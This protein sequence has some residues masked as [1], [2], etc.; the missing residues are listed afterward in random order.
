MPN[1]GMK[2][3]MKKPES[4]RKADEDAMKA[5]WDAWMK[6]HAG[7]VKETAGAGKTTRV[8][9]NGSSASANDVMLFSLVEA[10]SAEEASKLFEG[11]PHLKIPGA[12]ID[13]MPANYLPGMS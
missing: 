8:T 5:E 1:D 6:T 4:E 12:W 11:H 3:W 7:S 2:E 13:V 9:E 10:A